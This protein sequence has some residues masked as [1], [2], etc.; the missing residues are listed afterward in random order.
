[1]ISPE[2]FDSRIYYVIPTASVN[3]IDFTEVLEAGV[4]TLRYNSDESK[5]FVC[6]ESISIPPSLL[7]I[8]EK[9]GPYTNEQMLSILDTEGWRVITE[10]LPSE[11]DEFLD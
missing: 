6:Y 1:M 2:A 11:P 4:N 3:R 7:S 9:E 8:T 10:N 5:T